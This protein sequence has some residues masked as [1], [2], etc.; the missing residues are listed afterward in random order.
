MNSEGCLEFELSVPFKPLIQHMTNAF[1]SNNATERILFPGK[2][3]IQTRKVLMS[4]G[5]VLMSVE[6]PP[7]I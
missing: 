6:L 1:N 3:N 4:V 7:W 2:L 5:S